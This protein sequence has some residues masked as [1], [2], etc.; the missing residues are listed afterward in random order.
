MRGGAVP[1]TGELDGGDDGGDEGG[2]GGGDAGEGGGDRGDAGGA[3]G[4]TPA[5]RSLLTGFFNNE[6][7]QR[8][9]S[10]PPVRGRPTSTQC[11]CSSLCHVA[12]YTMLRSGSEWG[13]L[14]DT[15]VTEG[16]AGAPRGTRT[17]GH[18]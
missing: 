7:R 17:R 4:P 3:T 13:F 1:S 6:R 10:P 5:R 9:L 11:F 2:D 18:A 14:T 16:I 15:H 12:R 8:A